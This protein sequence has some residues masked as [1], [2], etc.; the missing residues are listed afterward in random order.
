MKRLPDKLYFLLEVEQSMYEM[1]MIYIYKLIGENSFFNNPIEQVFKNRG[2]PSEDMEWFKNP[3]PY[4]YDSSLLDNIDEAVSLLLDHIKKDNHIHLQIDKD[5]DGVSSSVILIN[6]LKEVYPNINLTW[7]NHTSEKKHGIDIDL[8]PSGTSLL[9]V[10]DASSSEYEIHEEVSKK[11][12]DI[13]ILDHHEAPYYSPF[14]IVV[15]NQLDNYP[16]KQIS[17]AGIVYKFIQHMDKRLGIDAHEKFVDLVAFGLIGDAMQISSKETYWLIKKGLSNIQNE[18]LKEFIKENVDWG[19]E[20]TPTVVAFKI[21]PKINSLLRVGSAEELDDI[22]KAFLGHQEITYNNRLRREDKSETWARRMTRTCNNTYARQRR[23][24][25]KLFEELDEQIREKKLYKNRFIVI[26]I[27]GDF[28]MNMSGYVAAFLVNKYLRPCLVLRKNED[29]ILVGSMRGYDPFMT[30]TKDFLNSLDTFILAEGH[31]NA[32][33]IQIKPENMFALN[34]KINKAL[35]SRPT[36]EPQLVDFEINAK[37]VTDS[38]IKEMDGWSYLWGQGIEEPMYAIKD[39]EVR[40]SDIQLIGKDKNVLKF[41]KGNIEYVQ[42]TADA[43]LLKLVESNK[44]MFLDIV[45]KVGINSWLGD[46]TSQVVIEAVRVTSQKE[47][48]FGGFV[49]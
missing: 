4:E 34:G 30:D 37:S 39:V 5:F 48:S 22:V 14:A 16:N 7:S 46:R 27:D 38:F 11:D 25:E 32:C 31:Q 43:E 17:G 3:T 28:E 45:G 35:E 2:I 9:I 47:D 15:N 26:E 33:G 44:T 13:L 36:N 40:A 20:L 18:M 24:R 6:Y 21:N 41:S 10:P 42:F 29:G 23:I 8:I 12:I 19:V 49:F 1:E